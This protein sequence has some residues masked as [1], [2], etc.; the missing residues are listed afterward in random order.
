MVTHKCATTA[1]L[2]SPAGAG[3]LLLLMIKPGNVKYESVDIICCWCRCRLP[4]G[5]TVPPECDGV[6]YWAGSS[7]HAA[8][9]TH[10]PVDILYRYRKVCIADTNFTHFSEIIIVSY[11][12]HGGE[13]GRHL[14][15][16]RYV[17]L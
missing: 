2:Q 3:V 11:I 14:T 16:V 6:M 4:C 17:H 10:S 9:S 1:P 5:G 12:A 8:L 7:T 13:G 15:M